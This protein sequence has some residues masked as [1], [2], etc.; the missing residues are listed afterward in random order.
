MSS[1][2]SFARHAAPEGEGLSWIELAQQALGRIV[3]V[4]NAAVRSRSAGAPSY[5]VSIAVS[6]ALLGS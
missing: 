5:A 6:A 4:L 1:M 3:P 2:L